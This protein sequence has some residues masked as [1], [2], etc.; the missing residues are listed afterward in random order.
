MRGAVLCLLGLAVVF[1]GCSAFGVDQETPTLTPADVPPAPTP[2][3][4][5]SPLAPGIVGDDVTDVDQLASSHL[6]AIANASYQW[7][8]TQREYRPT[9]DGRRVVAESRTEIITNGSAF[10]RKAAYDGGSPSRAGRYSY[11]RE[12]YGSGE[13][14]YVRQVSSRQGD[15][16]YGLAEEPA[17][18]PKHNRS[19]RESIVTHL[20]LTSADVTRVDFG[21]GAHLLVTGSLSDHATYGPVEE[22]RV[23]ALVR[24]D[25][26]VR[27][28]SANYTVV[29]DGERI[30]V[31]YRFVYT[32]PATDRVPPP[33]WLSEA[34]ERLDAETPADDERR[35]YPPPGIATNER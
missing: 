28:L 11:R 12:A 25:G 33:D 27:R 30:P 24:S 19:V 8:E 16:T 14:I 2:A 21:R 6:S 1:A 17:F 23:R 20:D 18:G 7:N 22:Y 34:R 31:E 15:P 26:F 10:Y 4:A 35:R 3:D 9:E 5:R 32:N 29:V 13:R